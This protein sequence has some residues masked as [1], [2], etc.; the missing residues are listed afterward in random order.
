M[1]P[2]S[3]P[4]FLA[5]GLVFGASVTDAA[6][7]GRGGAGGGFWEKM[8]GPGRW[9]YGSAYVSPCLKGK[10]IPGSECFC[11]PEGGDLWLNLGGS[12]AWTE[13]EDREDLESPPL[14]QISFEPS[15]DL[16]ATTLFGYAPLYFGIGGGVHHFWGQDVSLTRGSIEARFGIIFWRP[17]SL[18]FGFRFARK[19][20]FEG[21]TAGDFGDPTGTFTTNG[22]DVVSTYY[23]YV[24][25]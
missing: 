24:A 21:F 7:Q 1:R 22:T 14:Q 20:F 23:W 15:L 4:L 2:T 8:S 12:F 9:R 11:E 3:L 19:V 13:A 17:G 18:N 5:V 25:F 10:R 6:A 16:R